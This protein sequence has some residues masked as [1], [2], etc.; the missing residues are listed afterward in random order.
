MVMNETK[1][2][3]LLIHEGQVWYQNRDQ[4]PQA[5]GLSPEAFLD[6]PICRSAE[7]IRLPGRYQD[8]AFLLR[9]WQRRLLG[10]LND[11]RLCRPVPQIVQVPPDQAL[12]QMRHLTEAVEDWRP[13]AGHHAVLLSAAAVLHERPKQPDWL[14]KEENLSRFLKQHPAWPALSFLSSPMPPK[15]LDYPPI[16]LLM[17]CILDPRFFDRDSDLDDYLGCTSKFLPR[18][19]AP[20]VSQPLA[21]CHRSFLVQQLWNGVNDEVATAASFVGGFASRYFL[22]LLHSQIDQTTASLMASR[23]SLRFIQHAWT[24]ALY[25]DPGWREPTFDPVQFFGQI[26]EPDATAQAWAEHL[27]QCQQPT[28]QA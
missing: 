5:S 23:A 24:D 25:P 22:R 28:E 18:A 1:A 19:R 2:L 26:G 13:M 8:A 14:Y 21:R 27:Q 4:P 16:N 7:A 10:G 3:K 20:L 17:V 11:L 9:L 6:Q 15:Y 12:L